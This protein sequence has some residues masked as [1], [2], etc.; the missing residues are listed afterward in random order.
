MNKI[1][2]EC[3]SVGIFSKKCLHSII[4]TFF[5]KDEKIFKVGKI[6]NFSDETE[7]FEK[8]RSQLKMQLYKNGKAQ[9]VPVIAGRFFI[10]NC[11]YFFLCR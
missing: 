11:R 6:K 2:V 4:V 1:F 5:A 7:L 9:N 10:V 3:I 8:K